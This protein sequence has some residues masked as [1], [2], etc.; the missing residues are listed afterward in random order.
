MTKT[1]LA[2][3]LEDSA[4]QGSRK[5][6]A[7]IGLQDDTAHKDVNDLLALL[8]SW[9]AVKRTALQTAVRVITVGIL[10]A[11]AGYWFRGSL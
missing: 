10:A 11:I 5:A 8:E 3:L 1:E 4:E 7:S 6:L 9:R 2:T